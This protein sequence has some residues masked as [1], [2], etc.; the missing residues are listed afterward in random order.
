M[1]EAPVETPV[2]EP[3]QAEIVRGIMLQAQ[4]VARDAK[5]KVERELKGFYVDFL[6]GKLNLTKYR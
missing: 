2:D 4:S 5:A 1:S 3:S 6:F